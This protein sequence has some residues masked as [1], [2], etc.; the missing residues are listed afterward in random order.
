[1]IPSIDA[2]AV[3]LK[4]SPRTV[5]RAR[6]VL[7]HGLPEVARAVEAG[8]VTVATASAIARLP[9]ER[10]AEILRDYASR[11]EGRR[12]F[13]I[14]QQELTKKKLAARRQARDVRE[15]VEG[16][17]V[18]AL[19]DRKY[20]LILADPPS[21]HRN[22]GELGESRAAKH[23]YRTMS[24][25]ELQALE[26]G[27]LAADNCILALWSTVPHLV[28]NICLAQAWGFLTLVTDPMTGYLQPAGTDQ[29]YY[30]SNWNWIKELM[31]TGRWGRVDHEHLLIFRRG[32]PVAPALGTQP[33]S[34]I[35]VNR[36]R[37]EADDAPSSIDEAASFRSR[38]SQ[39]H[40]EKPAAVAEVLERLFPFT[41][42]IELFCREPRPDW[43][44][45]GDEIG[46]VDGGARDLS[47][48]KVS[49]DAA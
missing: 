31:G 11:P 34:T 10:Q 30:A 4:V 20:G 42:K 23:H 46:F 26:I 7:D 41:P 32:Q 37:T 8:D 48:W 17:R 21:E 22:W 49:E 27:R 25:G 18:A 2:A 13:R 6:E 39:K 14:V 16:R 1:L 33:R 36:E 28:E 24:L 35:P 29:P 15:M 3:A 40:S 43:D 47:R 45:W 9:Q 38:Q 19:P 44:A 12:A 5:D